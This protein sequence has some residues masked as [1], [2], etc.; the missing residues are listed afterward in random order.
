MP[1]KYPIADRMCSARIPTMSTSAPLMKMAIVKAQ[2]AGLKIRPICSLVNRK[3]LLIGPATSPRIAKTIEVV[4]SDT[5]LATNSLCLA[6]YRSCKGCAALTIQP[7]PVSRNTS[8]FSGSRCRQ[9]KYGRAVRRCLST[10]LAAGLLHMSGIAGAA[11]QPALRF[12]PPPLKVP[13]LGDDREPHPA[14]AF[15]S[16][17]AP[18]LARRGIQ[19]TTALAPGTVLDAGRLAHYDA[20]ML[21]G[22]AASPVP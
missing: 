3:A 12:P 22:D 14:A 20:G 5:Q 16:L 13:L 10:I 1:T 6:M 11:G 4:T 9:M 18:P 7:G 21:Y 8:F 19:I 15:Y 2:N 17:L